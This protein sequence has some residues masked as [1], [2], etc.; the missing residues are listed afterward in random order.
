[1]IVPVVVDERREIDFGPI[2]AATR[3]LAA[4]VAKDALVIYE[5]TLPVGTTRDRFGP[6]L[7]AGQRPRARPG[8]LPRLQPGAGPRRSRHPRPPAL[9]EDRRRH[10]PGEHASRGRVLSV[11]P[12]RGDRGLGRGRC[13]DRGDDEAGGDDVPRRE[14]RLRQRARSVR[15]APR[16]RRHGGHRSR[17]L[18]AVQP[19]PPAGRRGRR[20]LHPGVPALPLQRR[21]RPAAAADGPRDQRVHGSLHRRHDR[22]P[23]RLARRPGRSSC[24]ASPIAAT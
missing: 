21:A 11:R 1:M 23:H 24:S 13:R 9:P 14:H 7:T 17:Q 22:G 16:P 5:T 6:M 20:P 18:A 3:D 4:N 8:P 2:D 19:H 12:R 15:G 10:E